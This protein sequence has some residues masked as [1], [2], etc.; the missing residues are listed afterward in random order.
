VNIYAKHKSSNKYILYHRFVTRKHDRCHWR[1][2]KWLSFC[3]IPVIKG[4]RLIQSEVFCI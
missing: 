4:V 1:S 3:I 2:R